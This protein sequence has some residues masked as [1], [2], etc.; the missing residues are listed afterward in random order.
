MQSRTYTL[1][2][3]GGIAVAAAVATV[4]AFQFLGLIGPSASTMLQMIGASALIAM[5]A[6][7]M[8]PKAFHNGPSYSGVL[9]AG[10]FSGLLLIAALLR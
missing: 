5:A 7:T 1:G 2:L 10:G 4:F 8:T 6:E 3:W 9:A